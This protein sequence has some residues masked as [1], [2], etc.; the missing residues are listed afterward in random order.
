VSTRPLPPLLA[1]LLLA[2]CAID[3]SPRL[4][5]IVA[6]RGA[7]DLAPEN[8]LAAFRLAWEQGADLV[9]GDFHLT[10]DGAI[11]CHHDRTTAKT[12][13]VDRP[14]A[15][16]TLAEL[17]QLDVGRWKDPKWTGERIPTLP[18]VLD[19]VP[20][21][22]A[23]LIEVKTDVRIVPALVETMRDSGI[24]RGRLIVICFDAEVIAALE[25]LHPEIRTLWLSD[26]EADGAGGWTPPLA[27]LV[28]TAGRI[29]TDG[30]DL[31]ANLDVLDEAFVA[32]V[33]RAGLELHV[34]TVNDADVARR[35]DEL[36]VDG[37]TTDRPGWLR[38]Q[39]AMPVAGPPSP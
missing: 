13:G 38:A 26:F 11:V 1:V 14:V 9:E 32:A 4:P 34:W 15:A 35:L 8:T 16:Q 23:I 10:R 30:L 37:I 17:R 29:G 28:E 5:L 19:T 3:D 25:L 12:A 36:G 39:L 6:H 20:D 24:D 33:R 21:G 18:E 22:R 27:S 2:G 7:S 31:E